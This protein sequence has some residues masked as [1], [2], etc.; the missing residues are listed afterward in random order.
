M[1]GKSRAHGT[2]QRTWFFLHHYLQVT[3][4]L[5]VVRRLLHLQPHVWIAGGK[6]TDTRRKTEWH[7]YYKSKGN[8]EMS[9]GLLLLPLGHMVTPA[10][11]NTV[12]FSISHGYVAIISKIVVLLVNRRGKM[13]VSRRLAARA[14]CSWGEFAL[15]LAL[16][17]P[18]SSLPH[19]EFLCQFPTTLSYNPKLL[20]I[21]HTNQGK[22]K[23][24]QPQ[25]LSLV[26]KGQRF[27]TY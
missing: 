11:R 21:L 1:A 24:V 7:L 23:K 4:V 5:K 10:A 16:E 6:N 18:H 19:G 27:V 25:N 3:F 15:H 17:R 13:L 9:T 22:D 14:R 8:P 26:P 20:F 12:Q 2:T